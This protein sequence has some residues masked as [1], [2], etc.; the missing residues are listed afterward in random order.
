MAAAR[1][2]KLTAL[3]SSL[4]INNSRTF[5]L[6]TVSPNVSRP[7]PR[8]RLRLRSDALLQAGTHPRAGMHRRRTTWTR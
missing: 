5:L 6:A 1:D 7:P 8:P 4:M 2:T 3:L